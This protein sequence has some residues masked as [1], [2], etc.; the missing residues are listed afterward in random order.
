MGGSVRLGCLIGVLT[1]GPRS[2]V[3]IFQLPVLQEWGWGSDIFSLDD[4]ALARFRNRSVGFVF[5]FHHLLP[6][7][8]ALENAMLPG[9]ISDTPREKAEQKADE[10]ANDKAK[11][12]GNE[13]ADAKEIAKIPTDQKSLE[14][15]YPAETKAELKKLRDALTDPTSWTEGTPPRTISPEARV[16]WLE[17][18]FG[19]GGDLTTCNT[20][21]AG[22]ASL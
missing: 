9:L 21:T 2:A 14:A 11:E 10:A 20:W 19:S 16:R 7:F 1:F 15:L 13:K 3:G 12:A 22:L 18:G 8:N 6:E 5:Q 4:A 17:A